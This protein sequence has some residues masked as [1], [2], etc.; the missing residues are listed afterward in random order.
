MCGKGR[1]KRGN[2]T[3]GDFNLRVRGGY[4]VVQV[5]HGRGVHRSCEYRFQ[6]LFLG[7]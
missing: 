2:G 3:I 7:S 5:V 1:K 6:H 4:R